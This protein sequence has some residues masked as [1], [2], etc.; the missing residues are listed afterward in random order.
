MNSDQVADY[1]L[2]LLIKSAE[3]VNVWNREK[4]ASHYE[5][6]GREFAGT[7]GYIMAR[8]L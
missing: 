1:T 3:L 5:I 6:L 8:V 4:M 7:A 2:N